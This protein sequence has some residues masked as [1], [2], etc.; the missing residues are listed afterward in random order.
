[1]ELI[2]KMQIGNTKLEAYIDEIPTKEQ[3]RNKLISIY[4]KIH[5]IARNAEKR[6]VDTSKWFYTTDE[7]KK[8]KEQN[9]ELFI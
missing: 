6:G 8:I 5:E 4:D 1:M 9:P 3:I 7:I 2:K